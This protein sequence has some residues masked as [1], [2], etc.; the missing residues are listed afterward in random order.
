MYLYIIS[1]MMIMRCSGSD[2]NGSAPLYYMGQEPPGLQ[3]KVF[4]LGL[5]SLS[6]RYEHALC[7]SM[8]GRECYL[9]V[10]SADWSIKQILVMNYED[11]QWTPPVQASF[12]DNESESPCL[13][14]NDQF[15][16]FGRS[17]DIWRTRRTTQGWSEPEL[18]PAPVS[19]PEGEFSCHISSLG[20]LWICSWRSG[21]LGRCDI[22]R[23]SLS[24]GQFKDATAL[25]SLNTSLSDCHPIT[26]PDEQ[27]VLFYSNR[28]GGFGGADL[29]VSFP[30]GKGGWISPRNLGRTIN[31]S[32]NDM[33]PY[34]SSDYKYLFFNR[35]SS[36]GDTDIYWVRTEAFLPDPN[37][38]IVNLTT[39]QTFGSI[40]CAVNY[41]LPSEVI[42]VGP[43]VYNEPVT[44][45]K[46]IVVKSIDPNNP[47]YVGGTI[48]NGQSQDSVLTLSTNTTA[49]EIAGMTI[50]AGSVGFTGSATNATI[51][52]CRIVALR[53]GN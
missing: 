21:G 32:K 4:A 44:I 18:L 31:T 6:N 3:P 48:I 10:R 29:Y 13:T 51:R 8:D 15:L 42:E 12:S 33:V 16:Y 20:N 52:N 47:F 46:D 50:R 41:A 43:G 34:L 17:V 45:D 30:D 11:G 37:G 9:V 23:L 1:F 26:G 28:P 35:E 19:S 38:T 49:C 39:G 14:D 7:L 27:Y 40:Q 36:G 2:T 24:D 22:W 5:I 25:R 53:T